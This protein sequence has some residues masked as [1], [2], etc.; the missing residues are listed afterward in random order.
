MEQDLVHRLS[1]LRATVVDAAI[2]STSALEVLVASLYAGNCA[3]VEHACRVSHHARG[4]A[5]TLG[6]TG[7][8]L[9]DIE[10]AGLLHD[11]GKLALPERIT[12]KATPLTDHEMTLFRTHPELGA[13][14][15]RS[16]PFLCGAA[17]VIAATRERYDGSGYPSGL[18][19]DAIPIGSGIVAIAELFDSLVGTSVAGDPVPVAAANA[20]LVRAAGTCFDP[21]LVAAWM[22][23]SE[24]GLLQPVW[25]AAPG[26]GT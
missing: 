8:V 23:Y 19:S 12:S 10:R 21:L 11:I 17:V 18:R 7:A 25:G 26:S 6:V 5:S 2:A 24:A 14:A 20:D 15:I 4:L 1:R 9:D 3:A 13:E 16:V 22:R